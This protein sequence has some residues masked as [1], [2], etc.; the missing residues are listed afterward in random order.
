LIP[1]K[2]SHHLRSALGRK[3]GDTLL[4]GV[5]NGPLA[6]VRILADNGFCL[7]VEAP[8][9]P[10]PPRPPLDLALALPRPKVMNRLWP[11]LA[12]FG[13][14]RLTLFGT[15]D[16]PPDYFGAHTL[17]PDH[18]LPLLIDGLEQARCTALPRVRILPRFRDALSAVT[19]DLT[20]HPDTLA[21]VGDPAA[22]LRIRHAAIALPAPP[23]RATLVVGPEAGW[24]TD[25]L[26]AWTSHGFSPVTLG[27]RALRTDTA[28]I[29]LLALARD[30]LTEIA[31]TT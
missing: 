21:V 16:T 7:H 18:H 22:P 5:V 19:D 26:A 23:R 4:V 14:D 17:H 31:P 13:I 24:R 9:G 12:A 2:E 1:Q 20:A 3:P 30:A 11:T 29:A 27:P 15:T 10:V 25:E 6:P 8:T 28:V